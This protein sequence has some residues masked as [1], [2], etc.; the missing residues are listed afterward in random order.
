MKSVLVII[1]ALAGAATG[2]FYLGNY[3]GEMALEMSNIE[4]PEQGDNI[5][6]FAFLAATAASLAVG[7]LI[8]LGIGSLFGGKSAKS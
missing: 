6:A 8:G 5:H 1:G 7:W 2:I 4:S 3:A